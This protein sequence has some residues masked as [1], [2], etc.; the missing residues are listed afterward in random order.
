MEDILQQVITDK[1]TEF[2]KLNEFFKEFDCSE[3]VPILN[4]INKDSL[5]KSYF[6]GLHHSQKVCL[7]AYI[8]G[9]SL[10]LDDTDMKIILDAAIYHDIG[11]LNDAEDPFHGYNSARNIDNIVQADIYKERINLTYLRAICDSHSIEDSKRETIYQNY[12]YEEADLDREK[13]ILLDSILKDADALDRTRFR[14]TTDAA[15]KVKYLRLE[16]SRHL[17]ELSNLINNYY[18]FKDSENKYNEQKEFYEGPAE[19]D[20]FHGIGFDFFKFESILKNGILSRYQSVK[21]NVSVTRNFNGNNNDLWISVVDAKGIQKDGKA[22]NEFIKSGISFYCFVPKLKDGEKRSKS[23]DYNTAV[24]SGEYCDE[25]F[26]FNK[27]GYDNIHSIVIVKDIWNKDISTLNYLYGSNNVD[28]ISDKVFRYA[29]NIEEKS[30][31]KIDLTK[32]TELLNI[33]K[34]KILEF[35]LKPTNE[36][37]A[38]IYELNEES[39]CIIAKINNE[40]QKWMVDYYQTIFNKDG[41]IQVS[42]VVTDILNRKNINI[43]DCYDNEEMV[44]ILNHTK[45][46][47]LT[48]KTK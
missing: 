8:I 47:E 23:S 33:F 35:E 22:Y 40:V 12:K 6:H 29:K 45:K 46:E 3:L 41:V 43:E 1:N 10:N 4:S 14:R 18:R 21:E 25:K 31:I 2:V 20:C 15:L 44:I 7:F 48:N 19:V 9:K 42:D 32:A 36:Q 11:R 5:Y 37:K 28:I 38:G 34:N 39:D 17:V 24:E 26:A 16:V 27:I 30:N 13:F